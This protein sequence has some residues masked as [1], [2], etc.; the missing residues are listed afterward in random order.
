MGSL[1][2]I[3][4]ILFY[5]FFILVPVYEN[6]DWK[7][8]HDYLRCGRG[9]N[10]TNCENYYTT[11]LRSPDICQNGGTCLPLNHTYSC[12]CPV[13][14]GG[15]NCQDNYTGCPDNPFRYKGQECEL[16]LARTYEESKRNNKLGGPFLCKTTGVTGVV[17]VTREALHWYKDENKKG[18]LKQ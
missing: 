5:A 11:C 3:F 6:V 12:L 10:G 15:P 14:F 2:K 1:K 4:S 18:C 13:N 7:G 8:W 16:S 17:T 9:V